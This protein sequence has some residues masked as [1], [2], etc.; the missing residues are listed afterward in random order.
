MALRRRNAEFEFGIRRASEP[1]EQGDDRATGWLHSWDSGDKER[2]ARWLEAMG[3]PVAVPPAGD[4]QAWGDPAGA[5]EVWT[6]EDTEAALAADD[7][8]TDEVIAWAD[9]DD[10]V[11]PLRADRRAAH[12]SAWAVDDVE[13]AVVDELHHGTEPAD[14]W[15]ERRL[16]DVWLRVDADHLDDPAGP[17]DD[18]ATVEAWP[19]DVDTDETAEEPV[20]IDL[21]RLERDAL[22]LAVAELQA[23]RAGLEAD[24]EDLVA[25]R[26]GA[27]AA[28]EAAN[29]LAADA[30]ARHTAVVAGLEQAEAEAR[31]VEA[32]QY[33]L[34]IALDAEVQVLAARRRRLVALRRRRPAR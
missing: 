32:E 22:R 34:W 14:A 26:D 5:P 21:D 1:V 23:E 3:R 7:R 29:Q 12:P 2:V 13:D 24:I 31:R 19:W 8:S 6:D 30:A 11:R 27:L 17:G 33:A 18:T 25:V 16:P 28:A 10:V 9:D 15:A 4:G 20:V